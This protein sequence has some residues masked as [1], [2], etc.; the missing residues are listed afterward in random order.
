MDY[1]YVVVGC[2]FAGATAARILAEQGNHNILMIDKRSHL[3]GNSF[4]RINQ[5]GIA[6]H[7]Y[8]PHIF[9][10]DNEEVYAFLSR[11]TKLNGY[12]HSVEAKCHDVLLP[13]PFNLVS[14]QRAFGPEKART[15]EEKLLQT[16]GENTK[17]SIFELMNCEDPLL[18]ELGQFIYENIYY[19]YTAKQWGEPPDAVSPKVLQRVPVQVSRYSQYFSAKYQGLPE[20]GYTDVFEKLVHHPKINC[21]LNT[22]FDKLFSL[23]DGKI[24]FRNK[25]FEG[26]ILYTGSLD[27]LF[28]Y[29]FG[30][31][32]YR[33]MRFCFET[34]ERPWY[35]EKGVINYTTSEK[36]TRITEFKH[37]TGQDNPYATTILK[38]YPT[39]FNLSGDLVPCY[40]IASPASQSLYEKYKDLLADYPQIHLAGRLA[41]Y[42]Y[43]DMDMVIYRAMQLAKSL[44]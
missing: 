10:T 9:H 34:Y 37:M 25:M 8:G 13:V 38:E 22:P 29:Q 20:K 23:K 26:T 18:K 7:Q 28:H 41:E 39:N 2:G 35:Q 42:Q 32:P 19:Y 1:Q 31:L 44:L 15:L 14:V 24:Y 6:I 12:I 4:D 40:P 27:E 33:S 21:A 16:Y 36:F 5:H 17:V 11:F 30:V 43:Y 3:G